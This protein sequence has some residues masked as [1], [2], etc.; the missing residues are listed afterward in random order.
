[1]SS[2]P[3]LEELKNYWKNSRQYFDELAKHYQT[4]DP[5][6]YRT[7]MLPF[8]STPLIT[9]STSGGSKSRL[10][11]IVVAMGVLIFGIAVA[12]FFLIMQTEKE[13]V[14]SVKHTITPDSVTSQDDSYS[15]DDL[16]SEDHFLLGSKYFGEKKYDRAEEHLKKIKRGDKYYQEAQQLL[17]AIKLA[18]QYNR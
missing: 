16:S 9:T 14:Q 1:M 8:Y 7:Y 15:T 17:K 13:E 3:S 18:R 11:S 2:G 4:E 5:E 6:Y 10:I 12:A